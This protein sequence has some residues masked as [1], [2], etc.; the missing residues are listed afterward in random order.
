MQAAG[1]EPTSV[2]YDLRGRPATA[3]RGTG[4]AARTSTFGYDLQDRLVSVTDPLGRTVGFA[5]DLADRVTT[6]TLPDGRQIGFLYDANGNVT[7]VTPPGRPAH[8]FGY[9]PVNLE[10]SYTP[11]VLDAMSPTTTAYNVDRQP[12]LITR[13]DGQTLS[14]GYDAGGRLRTLTQPR[15]ATTF[16]Y[17]PTTG[18]LTTIA[19]P[20]GGTL[21]Y[22]YDGA[23]VTSETWGGSVGAVAGS[24]SRTYDNDF[25]T[26]SESVN[27]ANAITF[28]Y[29]PDSLLTQ[30]GTLSL[31]RDPQTGFLAGTTLGSLTDTRS[32]STFGEL[33]GYRA[34]VGMTALLETQY[35]RDALGRITQK[36]ETIQGLTDTLTYTLTYTYDL[37]GRLTEVRTNGALI[38]GYAYDTN[39]NRLSRTT[40]SGTMNGTHDA[41]DRL[42]TYG[43]ATYTYTANGELQSKT[44][45]AGT[46]SYLYDVVGN[47]LGVT[48]PD[49]T[50]IDY[51]IDGRNRRIGKKVNGVLVQA[52]LYRD[53]L[54]PVVELDGNGAV[55]ARFVYG[56][57]P[58]VPDY[59]IRGT[60]T[61]RII[62]DHLGSPRLVVDTTTGTAVQRMDYDEFGNVILDTNPGF[63]PFG[64]AGGL[65]DRDTRLTRFGVRDYDAEAT[66]VM[67]MVAA[68]PG[69]SDQAGDDPAVAHGHPRHRAGRGRRHCRRA[70]RGRGL[71]AGTAAG[72]RAEDGPP[73]ASMNPSAHGVRAR[74]EEGVRDSG[75]WAGPGQRLSV[76][77]MTR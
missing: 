11:P 1:L 10:A 27:G 42:L 54:K 40:P 31:A 72:H 64:F 59:L 28:G 41:Q 45:P 43:E 47:L 71:A 68:R 53:Q 5:Y 30:A 35:T 73:D 62:T 56:T 17:H 58:L 22:T 57:S 29:D 19:T 49:G 60:A 6:Q 75:P 76:R 46:T 55:L 12:T 9:T 63:Q 74:G 50:A 25:R 36:T 61:Y 69:A 26:A 20:D 52:F 32:Y 34:A 37:A 66:L 33:S 8:G 48:L 7:S 24:V 77:P 39:G 44:T 21:A 67:A 2:T 70:L 16:G 38:A 23:L 14:F 51:V 13:P 4:P 18:Q 3:T 65:H 15:G